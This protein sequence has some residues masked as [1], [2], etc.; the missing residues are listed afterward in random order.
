MQDDE[1]HASLAADREK[2]M[3]ALQDA[4]SRQHL[5]EEVANAAKA[6][7]HMEKEKEAL[8]LQTAQ[9]LAYQPPLLLPPPPPM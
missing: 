2:E 7:E 9:V 4:Q 3:R 8:H 5:A 1:Y 6:E